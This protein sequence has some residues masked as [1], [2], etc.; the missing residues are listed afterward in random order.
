MNFVLQIPVRYKTIFSAY[1]S[2]SIILSCKFVTVP[3]LLLYLPRQEYA[4]LAVLA[5]I[6]AWFL[7][8]DFGMGSSAQNTLAENQVEGIEEG[9]FIKTTL[10]VSC[11]SLFIG[12]FVLYYLAPALSGFFLP[13]LGSVEKIQ[14]IFSLAGCFFVLGT[15]GSIGGK[16]LVARQKGYQMYLVQSAAHL[17]SLACIVGVSLF[18]NLSLPIALVFSLGIPAIASFLLTIKIFYQADWKGPFQWKMLRRAKDFWLFALLAAI[19][20]L[21]DSLIITRTLSIEEWQWARVAHSDFDWPTRASGQGG[22]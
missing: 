2:R 18:G 13:K 6:E 20:S 9:S 11:F 8:L 1:L 3:I 4:I 5:G 7:L 22:E 12:G 19:V 15:W 14:E 21:S 10:L 16:I 17:I